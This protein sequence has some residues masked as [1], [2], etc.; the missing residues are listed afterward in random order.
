MILKYVTSC[1]LLILMMSCTSKTQSLENLFCNNEVKE[2]FGGDDSLPIVPL[3]YKTFKDSLDDYLKPYIANTVND[4]EYRVK[5]TPDS[6]F[7][8]YYLKL[9]YTNPKA[10]PAMLKRNMIEIRLNSAGQI[11]F[12]GDILEFDSVAKGIYTYFKKE[13]DKYNYS[14]ESLK[15]I[16]ICFAWDRGVDKKPF[17]KVMWN[18]VDGSY[19]FLGYVCMIE[20]DK[21][22]CEMDAKEKSNIFNNLGFKLWLGNATPFPPPPNTI[23]SS[24]AY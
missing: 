22:I 1:F 20:Y 19:D 5:I 6:L 23:T 12:E 17:D 2:F 10:P 9:Q 14:L 24:S 21:S 3:N 7:E 18:I 15:Y 8:P 4:I 11:L 16:G 13:H